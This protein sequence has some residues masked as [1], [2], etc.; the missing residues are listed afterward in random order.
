MRL[1]EVATPRPGEGE[2]LLR[3]EYAALNPADAY[4]AEGLYPA[5]PPF[6]HVLGRDG[7]G[8]VEAV[9]PNVAGVGAG[10]RKVVLR[11]EA[12]VSRWGTLAEFVAVPVESL[13]E[14]PAGWTA[15]E[16]S[17][18]AL[19]YVTAYQALTQ[20]EDIPGD[21]V[22]LISGASGGVGIAAF[23]LAAAMGFKAIGLSRDGEKRKRLE[24]LGLALALDPADSGWRS[25][26]GTFLGKRKVDLAVDSV[27]GALFPELI[28]TLG[29]RGRVSVVGRLAGDTPRFNTATLLFRRIRIGG[30]AVGAYTAAES[31]TVWTRIVELLNRTGARPLVDAV[32]DFEDLPGAFARLAAGPMGKVLVRAPRA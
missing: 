17:G 22:V 30:V 3:V 19:V 4:L 23:E 25:A 13:I 9:G 26:L 6:P 2:V 11:G 28:A 14:V 8:I 27:G 7:S 18:A 32:F 24:S 10:Q 20:W 21:A 1:A 16:A 31:R 29:N 15:E 12:G 5:K